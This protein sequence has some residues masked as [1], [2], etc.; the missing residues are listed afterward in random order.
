MDE[1]VGVI[2]ER[3]AAI[4]EDLGKLE[5]MLE[6]LKVS[7]DKSAT[8]QGERIGLLEQQNVEI[9]RDFH[10]SIRLAAA[11]QNT[12]VG[13]QRAVYDYGPIRTPATGV[14]T[15]ATVYRDGRIVAAA[16]YSIAAPIPG[17]SVIRFTRAQRDGQGTPMRIQ[18][19]LVSTEFHQ[20]DPGPIDR[21]PSPAK[22]V[23]FLLEDATYGLG[24]ATAAGSFA[25]AASDY[26]AVGYKVSGGLD[27][28]TPAVDV[29][30]QLLLR[31]AVLERDSSGAFTL[32]V[33]KASRHALA[34]S[35]PSR[36]RPTSW[37]PRCAPA[38]FATRSGSPIRAA[39]SARR[40]RG[41]RLPSSRA[42]TVRDRRSRSTTRRGC[43]GSSRRT[44]G[45]R[46]ARRIG[47]TSIAT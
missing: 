41:R 37:R 30:R 16:E 25:Q 33:D 27:A 5:G 34:A 7:F 2:V 36:N 29:L 17:L 42:A 10:W 21:G 23:K 11:G 12:L 13:T 44:S 19:D 43:L 6:S 28:R 3:I 24:K 45:R 4:K 32:D 31:G 22:V 38:S 46:S 1:G 9:R 20:V 47:R 14:L 15:V 35:P 8:K 18:A 40:R 39:R 26:G